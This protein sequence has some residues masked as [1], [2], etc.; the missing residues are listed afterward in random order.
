MWS[1][2]Q[3][4]ASTRL[5]LAAPF[6]IGIDI[7]GDFTVRTLIAGKRFQAVAMSVDKSSIVG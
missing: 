7:G 4:S 1:Q 6:G 3:A 5:A 2:G